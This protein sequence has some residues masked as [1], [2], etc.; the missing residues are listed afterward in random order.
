[1]TTATTSIATDTIL[2]LDLG[3]YKSVACL[4]RSP[5]DPRFTTVP[6]S[7]HEL[8]R[9]IHKHRPG[10]VLIE[11]RLLAGWV[12]DLCAE[13]GVTCLVA[14]TASEAWKF[15]HLKRKTDR[16]DATRGAGETLHLGKP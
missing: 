13:L 14:N 3:K 6:T 4:H 15:K 11:A 2:A 8:T 12:R 10:V 16:D 7:R 1:M 5:D 9:L